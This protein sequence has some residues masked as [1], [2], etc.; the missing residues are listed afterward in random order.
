MQEGQDHVLAARNA[1]QR[2]AWNE[3]LAQFDLADKTARLEADD[4]STYAIAAKW[5]SLPDR[6]RELFERAF[7]AFTNRGDKAHATEMA[8]ELC[9][10]HMHLR[11][12]A[13]AS[14]WFRRAERLIADVPESTTHGKLAWSRS[15]MAQGKSD[16]AASLEFAGQA[17]AI[18]ERTGDRDGLAL[19]LLRR[20]RVLV[21]LGKVD[22]GMA[23]VDE[24]MVAAVSGE[25]SAMVT[26][27]IYCAT[28]AACHDLCDYDRA[29]EWTEAAR[30]WCERK[31]ITGFPG[32]CRVHRAEILRLRGH[33]R[34]AESEAR[35]AS[36]EL[37]DFGALDITG[38]A[39]YEIGEVRLRM[40]DL[41]EAMESFRQAHELGR[42][43]QPG[44]AQLWLERGRVETA[45]GLI[46][47]AVA[48]LP[49]ADPLRRVRLLPAL[50]EIS[51]AAGDV[52]T[53]KAAA[54]E[55]EAC[56][57]TFAT[58]GI[59]AAAWTA[60]GMVEVANGEAK[61][62]ITTLRRA[63]QL[64]QQIDAPFESA[65][66]RL[67]LAHAYRAQGD[68]E[69]A[70]LETQA[71]RVALEKLGAVL[72]LQRTREAVPPPSSPAIEAS[73]DSPPAP[74]DLIDDRIELLRMIGGGGMGMVFEARNTRT[75]RHVAVKLLRRE[76]CTDAGA[77]QRLLQEAIA[78]GRIQHPNVVD[79]YDAGIHRTR[80]YVVMELLRG[81]SLGARL[82][83][84]GKL[85]I[86]IA[87]PIVQQSLAGLAA[88]HAA[89]IV[90][91]DIKPD[92]LFLVDNDSSVPLVK[93]LDFGISKL[94]GPE[95]KL[96]D[97]K[98]GMIVGTPFYMSP[99][100][101]QGKKEIDHRTDIYG[102]GAVLFHAITGRMPFEGE[103]YNALLAAILTTEVPRPRSLCGEIPLALE[104]VILRAMARDT[105][106]RYRNAAELAADLTAASA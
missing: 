42:D 50:C 25:L 45:H 20:G 105:G 28:I 36:E 51:L 11:E 68:E 1:M 30:R 95:S 21:K 70:K 73:G 57:K 64:W 97:T 67:S 31:S 9:G 2:H 69:T 19:A 8:L 87:V 54:D 103:N 12:H 90:H 7:N 85:P 99:E 84:D 65:Q 56:S 4:L 86:R 91:R 39:F 102:L 63:V 66:T 14:G 18:A 22:E 43:P 98:T 76:L 74:G 80:P 61:N 100:Q 33:F 13:I 60:R 101:A 92:N 24:A 40:G 15:M 53:A 71:A 93:V 88:A 81:E 82:D 58:P 48:D 34:E 16:L 5:C 17:L 55:L 32:I 3:A 62:A 10:H 44:L 6:T 38:E 35:R 72:A 47:R 104:A 78:C 27:T 106:M 96:T 89:G 52:P 83:R 41:D 75:G 37:R 79:V 59:E 94:V 26:G 23:D 49:Q 46:T 77:C 29:G